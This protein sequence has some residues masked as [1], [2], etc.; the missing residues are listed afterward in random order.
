MR[1]QMASNNST[2]SRYHGLDSVRAVAMMLGIILHAALP[3]MDVGGGIWPSDKEDSLLLAIIVQF[4]HLW[5]MPLFFILS[6]FFAGLLAEKHS[7]T[8][9]GKN[10]AIRIGIPILI[11][12]P[13]MGLTMPWIF[14]YGFTR[15]LH[16]YYSN[17]GMPYHLW[18][19]WHLLII[20]AALGVHKTIGFITGKLLSAVNLHQLI[21]L[22][23]K[24][25][26]G[27]NKLVF[28]P[29][30]PLILILILTSLSLS[31][32]GTEL[33]ENPISTGIYFAFGYSLYWNK[34]LFAFIK[35]H[36]EKYLVASILLF[37]V[38]TALEENFTSLDFESYDGLM[39]IAFL[40]V[41]IS[42]AVFFSLAFIGLAEE[43]F[44]S[45]KPA[46][47]Y[48]SDGSY[49]IYLIHLP[50]VTFITFSMFE[51]RLAAEIKFLIATSLT[52]IICLLTYK[53]F[54]RSSFVGKLLNGKQ[55]PFKPN[56]FE[57]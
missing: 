28:K 21:A 18:F 49:W 23:R 7:W 6:G 30:L 39:W 20:G 47:R 14:G 53:Y 31:S 13:L 38:H 40:L 11:F 35:S 9:W 42:N 56:L 34:T 4:I 45:Y 8:Y 19:L 37:L 43:R 24:I 27:V 32:N 1:V 57:L 25:K 44:G 16:F 12:S 51:F 3:Y 2:N 17:E 48:I 41:K 36:W 22:S 26:S 54:V 52:S 46:V 55:H 10:R 5:R 15:E 50:V 33:F 29:R